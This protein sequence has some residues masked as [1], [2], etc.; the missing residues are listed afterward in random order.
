MPISRPLAA[1]LLAAALLSPRRLASALPRFE[2]DGRDRRQYQAAGGIAAAGDRR[3]GFHI[4]ETSDAKLDAQGLSVEDY[5][6]YGIGKSLDH[7]GAVHSGRL[8]PRA[9][10]NR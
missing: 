6:G 2:I 1:M 4:V 9:Q 7:V 10:A 8:L 5:T 3:I